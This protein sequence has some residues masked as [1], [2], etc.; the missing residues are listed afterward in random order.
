MV[1][2]IIDGGTTEGTTWRNIS[3]V[4]ISWITIYKKYFFFCKNPDANN[5]QNHAIQLQKYLSPVSDSSSS[6]KIVC[7]ETAEII[8]SNTNF[9]VNINIFHTTKK[10]HEYFFSLS[11]IRTNTFS[12]NRQVQ[13]VSKV[14]APRKDFQNA[15]FHP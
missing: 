13:Y 9:I 10:I 6:G 4:H 5:F 7:D 15:N 12:T 3:K 11:V 2:L 14:R 1:P 8:V